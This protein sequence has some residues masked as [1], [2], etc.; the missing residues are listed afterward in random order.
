[1][2]NSKKSNSSNSTLSCYI[3]FITSILYIVLIAW[4]LTKNYEISSTTSNTTTIETTTIEERNK[5]VN[6]AFSLLFFIL[7]VITLIS[8]V[9]L[10]KYGTAE[11]LKFN[12]KLFFILPYILLFWSLLIVNAV[13]YKI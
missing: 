13:T 5:K 7:F 10:I 3:P 6:C 9:V 12:S 1:M 8:V 2:G 11:F 4:I